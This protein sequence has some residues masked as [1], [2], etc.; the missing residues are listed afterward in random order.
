[1]YQLTEARLYHYWSGWVDSLET[2]NFRGI[3]N[4]VGQDSFAE[5]L[6]LKV[7]GSEAVYLTSSGMEHSRTSATFI[8]FYLLTNAVLLHTAVL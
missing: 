4:V 8:V 5:N 6:S 3:I 1:M 7:G 2:L